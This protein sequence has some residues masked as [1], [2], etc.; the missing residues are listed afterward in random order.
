M[1]WGWI[2]PFMP[3]RR[4]AAHLYWAL[5]SAYMR[6]F[7]TDIKHGPGASLWPL[8]VSRKP[9]TAKGYPGQW[10][11]GRP[12]LYSEE[13]ERYRER[14]E[15]KVGGEGCTLQ[16]CPKA[17]TASPWAPGVVHSHATTGTVTARFP[18]T[19]STLPTHFIS[20]AAVKSI[21]EA[22]IACFSPHSPQV[23]VRFPKAGILSR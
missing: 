16:L 9:L 15:G 20:L 22:F 14:R 8:Y 12:G 17:I 10:Q 21:L 3:A 1:H 6:A 11:P 5:T 2:V 23:M 19:H 7:W 13:R 18:P 4:G